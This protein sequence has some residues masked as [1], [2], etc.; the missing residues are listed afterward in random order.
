M[1]LNQLNDDVLQIIISDLA[2][3]I[4]TGNA[5]LLHLALAC[6]SLCR[7]A[8]PVI[9][10]HIGLA[11]PS[12]KFGLFN[13]TL[14]ENPTYGHGVTWFWKST[15]SDHK[16]PPLPLADRAVH[17]FLSKLPNIRAFG[18]TYDQ[19]TKQ[20]LVSGNLPFRNTLQPLTLQQ[21]LNSAYELIDFLL[22]PRFAS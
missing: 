8:R 19:S 20:T 2:T 5:D 7:L 18:V 10:Q 12:R 16:T 14:D 17:S 3:N 11:I 22:L 21:T 9:C 13:R 4:W 15:P 6:R 1:L